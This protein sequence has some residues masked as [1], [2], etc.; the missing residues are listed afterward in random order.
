M[1]L[2]RLLSIINMDGGNLL[3][4]MLNSKQKREWCKR[5][6]GTLDPHD[7][8]QVF[9]RAIDHQSLNV[10]QIC[11]EQPDVLNR[12]EWKQY[13]IHAE[14]LQRCIQLCI[15][16]GKR[17]LATQYQALLDERG[18]FKRKLLNH[19]KEELPM[20]LSAALGGAGV[21]FGSLSWVERC[22]NQ[23]HSWVNPDL[24]LGG[25]V[26]KFVSDYLGL[27]IESSFQAPDFQTIMILS[28]IYSVGQFLLKSALEREP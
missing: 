13:A 25:L 5:E 22:F 24:I 8:W 12:R 26:G 21:A 18:T 9:R 1:D 10:L 11:A 14:D 7:T 16:K 4:K 27:R 19:V 23:P 20:D 2:G 6:I 3:F 15:D 28:L 17:E